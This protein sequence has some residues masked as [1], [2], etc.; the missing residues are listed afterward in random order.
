MSSIDLIADVLSFIDIPQA[1]AVLE[2]LQVLVEICSETIDVN[3][4]KASV[5]MGC[6]FSSGLGCQ[7]F[8]G[9]NAMI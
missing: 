4:A 8:P 7:I 9:N 6:S 3:L 1:I 5:H 2:L